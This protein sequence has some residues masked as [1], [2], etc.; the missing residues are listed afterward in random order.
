MKSTNL[1]LRIE[2]TQVLTETVSGSPDDT[3]PNYSAIF[4]PSSSTGA[5][6]CASI[7]PLL[8][9]V[10]ILQRRKKAYKAEAKI[11]YPASAPATGESLRLRIEEISDE[12]D[13]L[14]S[15]YA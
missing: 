14:Y 15:V 9:L 6:L 7:L 3:G 2:S 10:W 8:P 13:A 1:E 4:F 5:S 12:L 11:V